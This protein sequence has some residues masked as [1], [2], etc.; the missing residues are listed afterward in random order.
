MLGLGGGLASQVSIEL[1]QLMQNG[2]NPEF[3]NDSK[4]RLFEL[5]TANLKPGTILIIK[6]T[7][8]NRSVI[9]KKTILH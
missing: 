5:K 3:L 1:F 4:S 6:A 7:L 9:H 8:A 2:T